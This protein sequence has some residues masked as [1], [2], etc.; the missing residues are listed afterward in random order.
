[1]NKNNVYRPV[2][3]YVITFLITW[4]CQF[5]AAYFSYQKD[6]QNLAFLLMA[7]SLFAPFIATLIMI[8]RK[9]S[10]A[11]RKDF[12][13]RLNP[14][15][16]KLSY[17]PAILLIM[18]LTMIL[19]TAFSILLG[20]SANQF[21]LADTFEIVSGAT[22]LSVVILIMAPTLEEL[23]WRG[24]GVDSLRSKFNLFA[25]TLIFAVLWALWHLPLFFINGYYQNEIWRMSPVYGL[26]F[27]IQV[28]VA[29]F[30]MNWI[31][32]K[33][34][35]SIL[36]AI[37]FHFMFNLPSV[38]LQT[39]QFTKCLVTCILLVVSVLLVVRDC[40]MFFDQKKTDQAS[41]TS[42]EYECA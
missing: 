38:L 25:T 4:I 35:R 19:A 16:V 17:L 34:N 11:L 20:H 41:V 42:H 39:E 22:V 24:Y 31:Y 30:L 40:K 8:G 36:A 2:L 9:D 12:W 37:L 5:A 26:N 23:G 1:M 32:Y 6:T 15:L 33:N 7:P 13:T 29:A 3:F 18:P 27:F 10:Q 14:K 28:F 21:L